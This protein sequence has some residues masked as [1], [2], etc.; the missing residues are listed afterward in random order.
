MEDKKNIRD[1]K[2]T[3]DYKDIYLFASGSQTLSNIN[4]IKFKEN[5]GFCLFNKPHDNLS[6]YLDN[7]SIDY[8]FN[9]AHTHHL[10]KGSLKVLNSNYNLNNCIFFA[11]PKNKKDTDEIINVMKKKDITKEQF[12]HLKELIIDNKLNIFDYID[13]LGYER[14]RNKKKYHPSMGFIGIIMLSL[15][16]PKATFHLIGFSY[17]AEKKDTCHNHT[18]ENLYLK[19]YFLN[20]IIYY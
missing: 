5:A 1:I 8:C 10:Y 6:Q 15:L 12:I 14:L 13:K 18:W 16:H 17:M 11:S 19:N 3:H 9:R 20:K 2:I 4:N 7:K